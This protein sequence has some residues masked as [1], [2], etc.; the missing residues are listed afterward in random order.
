M[1]FSDKTLIRIL[2]VMRKPG[3]QKLQE[4]DW[5][6][7]AKTER[8]SAERHAH[9]NA[10]LLNDPEIYHVCYCWSVIT[11]ASFMLA[12][13]SAQEKGQTLFY[14]QAIDQALTLIR[15]GTQEEFYEDLLKIPSLSAT[16][17]LPAVTLWHVGMRMKFT[18]TL[19]QP[20]AVQDVECTVVGFEPDDR[21][22]EAIRAMKAKHCVGEHLCAFMPKAIYVKIDE[23]DHEFLPPSP[24][25]EH[26]FTGYSI[27]C[28]NCSCLSRSG[29]FAVKPQ[30][31]TFKYYHDPK[32][33]TA[34]ISVQ[35]KQFP[36][37]PARA[38]PLYSMQGTTADPGMVAYWFF[39]QRC[40][41]T[42]KWLI[43]YV[44]LSRPRCLASLIS[45]GLTKAVREIIEQG[46]PEQ[47][48]S[49]FR[50]LF[51]AKSIATTTQ[52]K[53]AAKKY[54]LMPGLIK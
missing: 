47:L 14:A 11:M 21:D 22:H 19:Q 2:G 46:P 30:V 51:E 54:G 32:N 7:L 36:L 45:V 6:A 43:V 3:G 42:V 35:R 27:E 33:N 15:H 41:P 34:Y 9:D 29:I 52:A 40:S 28:E 37:M 50:T 5:Q 31:R 10:A 24:C 1:R 20:F 23:C 25:D 44:M 53:T 13:A 18:T 39:P 49:S 17:K 4:E 8:G 26:R 48:V 16:K 38:M 12:R